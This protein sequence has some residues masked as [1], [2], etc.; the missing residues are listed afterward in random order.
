MDSAAPRPALWKGLLRAGVVLIKVFLCPME[1]LSASS[2]WAEQFSHLKRRFQILSQGSLLGVARAGL[3]G[4]RLRA[5]AHSGICKV[6][7]GLI[8]SANTYEAPTVCRHFS[9]HLA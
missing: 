4:G 3:A 5:Q 6:L 8:R 2:R 1:K 9:R 7:V